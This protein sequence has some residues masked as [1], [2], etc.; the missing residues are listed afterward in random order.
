MHAT[1]E[2]QPSQPRPNLWLVLL[3]ALSPFG[4]I[5]LMAL[6]LVWQSLH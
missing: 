2:Q 4:L 5:A 1:Y 3:G 6:P